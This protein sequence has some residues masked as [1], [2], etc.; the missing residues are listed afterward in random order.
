MNTTIFAYEEIEKITPGPA[1]QLLSNDG[2][3]IGFM[4]IEQVPMYMYLQLSA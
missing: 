1:F 3:G 4:D 2:G